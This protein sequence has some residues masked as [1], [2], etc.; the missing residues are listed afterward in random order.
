LVPKE[1]LA[2]ITLDRDA[3]NAII[4]V[5]VERIVVTLPLP[6]YPLWRLWERPKN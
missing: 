6:I 3:Y 2:S 4:G 1:K 5:P